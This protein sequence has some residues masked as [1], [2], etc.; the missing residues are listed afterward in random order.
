MPHIIIKAIGKPSE[1]QMRE[2][3]EQIADVI[4]KTMGKSK[5]HISV[6]IEDYSFGEWE[7]VYNEHIK[8]NDS[9]IVK[10]GYT[11]PKTFE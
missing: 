2:A 7:G 3:A 10:P 4:S 5:K 6:S 8:D 11:N 1:E 9:V